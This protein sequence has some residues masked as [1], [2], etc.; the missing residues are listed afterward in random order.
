MQRSCISQDEEWGPELL[1]E[2]Q[3]LM[4]QGLSL[5]LGAAMEAAEVGSDQGGYR[6]LAANDVG[7]DLQR[8]FSFGTREQS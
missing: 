1:V 5:I 8:R 3:T 4:W 2:E 7:W 6:Q